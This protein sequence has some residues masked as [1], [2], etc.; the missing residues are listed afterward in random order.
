MPNVSDAL[1]KPSG[2]GVPAYGSGKEVSQADLAGGTLTLTA[3]SMKKVHL[4]YSSVDGGKVKL[5]DCTAT[6]M[7]L[8]QYVGFRVLPGSRPVRIIN[9]GTA[10]TDAILEAVG[11]PGAD[12][13][14]FCY[15]VSSAKG[16]WR[17]RGTGMFHG[18]VA[19]TQPYVQEA[20]T[21]LG[22]VALVASMNLP[23]L[24]S[25]TCVARLS[26]TQYVVA[27]VPNAGTS[28]VLYPVSYNHSTDAWTWGASVTAFSSA[29]QWSFPRII[30]LSST[31]YAVT[32]WQATAATQSARAGTVAAN[33]ITQGSTITSGAWSVNASSSIALSN[34]SLVADSATTFFHVSRYDG[35]ALGITH[36][37]VSGANI[38]QD[39]G[40]TFAS[41]RPLPSFLGGYSPSANVIDIAATSTNTPGIGRYTYNAGAVTSTTDLKAPSS[42]TITAGD[43]IVIG[44][45]S[46]RSYWYGNGTTSVHKF[47]VNAGFTA[48]TN[49]SY[50]G[51]VLPAHDADTA[52]SIGSGFTMLSDDEGLIFNQATAGISCYLSL[53]NPTISLL[54]RVTAVQAATKSAD[55]AGKIVVAPLA[56]GPSIGGSSGAQIIGL[57]IDQTTRRVAVLHSNSGNSTAWKRL[58]LMAMLELPRNYDNA[59]V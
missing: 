22:S 19:V 51:P 31:T 25:D 44:N 53:F 40:G 49:E 26:A 54:S 36:F 41:A 16:N 15:S 58:L 43:C 8:G 56:F 21:D 32:A 3:G 37:S 11:L 57:N 18:A 20:G 7:A 45:A 27:V 12:F 55:L 47:T 13:A 30:G 46:A 34:C 14:L 50:L 28:V 4:I 6:G 52:R 2:G 35:T 29:N 5:P 1:A 17:G 24:T 42:A 10:G 38:T 48:I 33:V 9:A 39:G 59:T 23:G